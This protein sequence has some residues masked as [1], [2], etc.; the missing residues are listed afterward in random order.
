MSQK[1]G[2]GKIPEQPDEL[3][4]L[5]VQ[6]KP[7]R[8]GKPKGTKRADVRRPVNPPGVTIAPADHPNGAGKPQIIIDEV[9]LYEAARTHASYNH[10]GRIFGCSGQ[11]ILKNY[12]QLVEK[13]RAEKVQQLLTAQFDTAIVDRNP[14]MQIWL[15]KQYAGQRDV[16][17][18]EQTGADGKPIQNETT[19]RAVAYIPDNGRDRT[20]AVEE[21]PRALPQ[22][23]ESQKQLPGDV[24]EPLEDDLW[25]T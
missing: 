24:D 12:R 3:Y 14:T 13:A 25:D 6:G 8:D 2:N 10:L 15:G 16:S 4:P 23:L 1:N 5:N 11:H 18:I 21:L 19:Y 22:A 7:R 17:R 9:A 20:D